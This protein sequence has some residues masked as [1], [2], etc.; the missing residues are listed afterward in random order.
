MPGL[1]GNAEMRY[2]KP[3]HYVMKALLSSLLVVA[4]CEAAHAPVSLNGRTAVLNYTSSQYSYTETDPN[5]FYGW[6]SYHVAKQRRTAFYALNLKPKAT[7]H[8]LPITSPRRG[9]STCT[10]AAAVLWGGIEVNPAISVSGPT[11]WH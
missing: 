1:G 11:L 7:R 6:E 8:L 3:I 2:N 10:P 5:A 9:G 4:P